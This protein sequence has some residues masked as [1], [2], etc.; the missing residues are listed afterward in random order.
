MTAVR[1]RMEHLNVQLNNLCQVRQPPAQ[2][3]PRLNLNEL[4]C[5]T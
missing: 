2:R 5:I 1:E 4:H 3:A